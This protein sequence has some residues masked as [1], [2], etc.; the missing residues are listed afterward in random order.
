MLR[1]PAGEQTVKGLNFF[2]PMEQ[3]LLQ[4]MQ[5]GE[6]NIHGWRRADLIAEHVQLSPSALSAL[7]RQ[8][9]HLRILG[10]IKRWLIPIAFTSLVWG[11][12]S[13]AQP[14]S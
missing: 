3:R 2:N 10:L 6:F 9:A 7:S 14:A 11:A 8:L 4:T 5:H 13:L 1:V 12:A